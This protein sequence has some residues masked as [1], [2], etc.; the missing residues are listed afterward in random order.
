ML[1]MLASAQADA[2][3]ALEVDPDDAIGFGSDESASPEPA[4]TQSPPATGNPDDAVGFG[5]EPTPIAAAQSAADSGRLDDAPSRFRLNVD[6]SFQAAVRTLTAEPTRFARLR[7]VLR[8]NLGFKQPL[9]GSALLRANVGVHTEADFAYLAYDSKYDAATYKTEAWQAWPAE[10]YLSLALSGVEL[11]TGY[12]VLNLSQA[13]MLSL[14]ALVN[15]RDLREPLP[16]ELSDMYLP[17]LATRLSITLDA[18]RIEAIAVHEA[19]FGLMAPP[20]GEFSPVRKL[21]VDNPSLGTTF[22]DRELRY[23]HYPGRDVTDPGATQVYGRLSWV[24]SGIDVA[25]LGGSTLDR[26]GVPS[27]PQADPT[28]AS[29]L[30]L[31]M[32]HPR[33]AFVA[34]SGAYP[35]GPVLLRWEFTYDFARPLGVKRTDTNLLDWSGVRRDMASGLIGVS[36]AWSLLTSA[37]IEVRQSYVVY[38]PKRTPQLHLEP[39]FP[40]EAT[41]LALR[42]NSSFFDERVNLTALLLV[43]GLAPLNAWLGRIELSYRFMDQLE[44]SLGYTTY[45]PT[46]HFGFFYGFTQHDRLFLNLRLTFGS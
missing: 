33:Y 32:P 3:P 29:V 31:P 7:E 23:R 15:P 5:S 28:D 43:H 34:T 4:A 20:L 11:T 18:F 37:A 22:A 46:S 36:Y 24:G 30:D 2:A 26:F 12:Q 27:L 44:A 1:P 19:Y 21:L 14:L 45:R 39:I 42:F 25:V 35:T 10:T 6:M 8:L 38:N 9:G 16:A 13:E 41:Q 40:V 17:T